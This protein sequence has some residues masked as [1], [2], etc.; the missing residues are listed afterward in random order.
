MQ[1][2]SENHKIDKT[3]LLFN[4]FTNTDQTLEE[5]FKV[6]KIISIIKD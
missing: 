5:D 1:L 2:P 3:P 6:R 4:S